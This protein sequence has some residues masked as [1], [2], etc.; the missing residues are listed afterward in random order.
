MVSAPAAG[1]KSDNCL[2]PREPLAVNHR[3]RRVATSTHIT[4]LRS[5]GSHRARSGGRAADQQDEY[6]SLVLRTFIWGFP[7]QYQARAPAGTTIALEIPGIGAW[8]L[9][10]T[11]NRMV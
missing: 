3:A 11:G 2:L 4:R 8:T 5:D 9:T 1:V 10:R 6:L 7:H